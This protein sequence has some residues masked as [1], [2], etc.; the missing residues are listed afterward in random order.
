M[1]YAHVINA[2]NICPSSSSFNY[3]ESA[4]HV[5]HI[6]PSQ[7]SCTFTPAHNPQFHRFTSFSDFYL[8]SSYLFFPSTFFSSQYIYA[9]LHYPLRIYFLFY[10]L[11]VTP[12]STPLHSLSFV[13]F[14]STL[15]YTTG[16]VIIL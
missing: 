16:L 11:S 5:L 14:S 9:I 6:T 12:F 10:P 1:I 15:P 8:L 2:S 13:P 3:A 7:I 4:I